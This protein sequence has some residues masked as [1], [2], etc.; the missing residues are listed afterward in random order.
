[1]FRPPVR[2]MCVDVLED[3]W[4]NRESYAITFLPRIRANQVT[5]DVDLRA[6]VQKL[7]NK[8]RP[9]VLTG[10]IKSETP[11]D[12]KMTVNGSLATSDA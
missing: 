8:F 3:L 6:Q 12:T 10:N 7:I 9:E 2:E 5:A 4:R 11:A 1:M